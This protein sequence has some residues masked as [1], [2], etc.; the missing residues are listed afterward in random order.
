MKVFH[1][2]D[3][4]IEIVDLTKCKPGK[5]FG[6]GFYVTNIR[7]QAE[8]MAIRVAKWNNTQPIV[9]EFD[10]EIYA[11]EY[12]DLQTL[13]FPAYDEAWLD[14]IILNRNNLSRQSVHNFDIVEGP[15]A[16]DAISVRIKDYM[17]GKVSKEN[18]LEELK[19]NKNTHQICFCTLQ[20][21]QMLKK[22]SDEIGGSIYHIDDL[23]IQQLMI[24]YDFSD[25]YASNIYFD[26]NTYMLLTDENTEFYRKS[27]TNI[28]D[29]LVQELNL[30]KN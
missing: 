3:T 6:Q 8:E 5:D 2:S 13:R 24:D 23:I 1:G 14:F 11:F 19:F 12:N 30:M 21:L 10:F 20:S 25:M 22:I 27:W 28:Y 17:L 4:A 16:D 15:V 18:F 9:S 26:S 29:L 7:R